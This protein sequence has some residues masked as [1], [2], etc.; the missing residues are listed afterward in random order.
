[1]EALEGFINFWLHGCTRW[2]LA[3]WTLNGTR[4]QLA[5]EERWTSHV[6]QLGEGLEPSLYS[7][8]CHSHTTEITGLVA[9]TRRGPQ[10]V[11]TVCNTGTDAMGK[12]Q[13]CQ[14]IHGHCKGITQTLIPD[15]LAV[16]P[17]ASQST[18]GNLL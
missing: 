12:A 4:S 10:L 2:A 14:F 15:T 1:M 18:D 9:T 3:Y 5:S 7:A 13:G 16:K 8:A 11:L 17:K 6:Q